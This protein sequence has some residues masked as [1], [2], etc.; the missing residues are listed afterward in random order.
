[1]SFA[2]V[3]ACFVLLAALAPGSAPAA[4]WRLDPVHTRVVFIVGHA[5]LSRA[6]G[7]FSGAQ[8]RLEFDPEHWADARVELALP[9]ASLDLIGRPD[10]ASA[11]R[12]CSEREQ[13]CALRKPMVGSRRCADRQFAGHAACWSKAA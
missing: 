8:G 12:A 11:R 7:T 2:P 4:T 9:V 1:M 13:P 10:C 6:I 5:G 3:A